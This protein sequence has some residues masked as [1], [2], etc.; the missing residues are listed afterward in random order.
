MTRRLSVPGVLEPAAALAVF[1]SRPAS[2]QLKSAALQLLSF[3]QALAN[4][5]NSVTTRSSWSS[6]IGGSLAAA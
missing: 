1:L 4:A 3:P 5:S 6:N 2:F